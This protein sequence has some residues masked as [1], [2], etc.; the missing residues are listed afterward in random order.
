MPDIDSLQISISSNSTNAA[1]GI[2]RLSGSLETLK[3]KMAG[4][5]LRSLQF[6]AL[7]ASLK[8]L[9]SVAKPTGLNSTINALKKLPGVADELKKADLKTFTAQINQLSVAMAPLANQMSKISAGFASLP[10]N[11]GKASMAVNGYSSSA[12]AAT[13]A[14]KS[15]SGR[16]NGMLG[17]LS[18]ATIIRNVAQGIGSAVKTSMNYVENLNL[19]TV[20]MGEYA[21]EAQNYAEKVASIMGIDPSA[22]M[23]SQGVFMTLATGFGVSADR[24]N[25][26]SQNLTQLGYDLSSFFNIT[27]EDAME[28]LQSGISGELEPLRRLGYDLSQAKLEAT[29]LSLGIDKSVSSMTQAEKAQLRYYAIMTQVT[30]AQGDMARTLD[31]PA[32]QLRIFRAAIEQTSRAIGN[33]FIPALNKIFPYITAVVRAVQWVA[34]S[35]AGLFGFEITTVDYSGGISGIADG[36]EAVEDA[37]GGATGAAKEFKRQVMGFDELNILSSPSPSGG[38][39]G[40]DDQNFGDGFDFELPTYDFL[41]GVVESKAVGIF[42]DIKSLIEDIVDLVPKDTFSDLA[43]AFESLKTSLGDLAASN[44]AKILSELLKSIAA[45]G[46]EGAIT[47]LTNL[48]TT[49]SSFFTLIDSVIN[50]DFSNP[51]ESFWSL[52]DAG[53]ELGDSLA[54]I[55]GGPF[56]L[57]ASL[58]G[59][60]AINSIFGGE[61]NVPEWISSIISGELFDY[62]GSSEMYKEWGENIETYIVN[63]VE[64][65][66]EEI[67][68][69]FKDPGGWAKENITKP[70]SKKFEEAKEKVVGIWASVKTWFKTNVTEPIAGFFEEAKQNVVITW[71]S[72]TEWFNTN[73]KGPIVSTFEDVKQK[74][75]TRFETAK[76][77]VQNAWRT[78]SEWFNANVKNPVVSTFETLKQRIVTPIETAATAVKNAW[79]S[80]STWF[81]VNVVQPIKNLFKGIDIGLSI[82]WNYDAPDWQKTIGKALFGYNAWPQIGF[83]A[84]GGYGIPDGQLFVANE[85]GP[86]L[87][88]QMNGRN[89]VANQGQII[90][91]I[92]QATYEGFMAAMASAG[93]GNGTQHI[94]VQV[95]DGTIADVV[96]RAINKQ[97][98]ELG[99][100]ALEG[101]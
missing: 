21:D 16:F 27:V 9:M 55:M 53:N 51:L 98:Q 101:I 66:I 65:A 23:R 33:I 64:E 95:G 62:I 39:G 14:S 29:A 26:M 83:F 88:G 77:A 73:I 11:I 41:N 4:L 70:I 90:E 81:D 87:V 49:F 7:A 57:L 79:R 44:G 71:Q 32:N 69:I 96:V 61:E 18:A 2:D 67:K 80:I 54:K 3:T 59:E 92:R 76:T 78:I 75:V 34:E 60:K 100:L 20:A 47:S 94:T 12:V 30:T 63:P 58:L 31:Q 8:P 22:W 86:E 50:F 74:V 82:R 99:Y 1:K 45:L 97:T 17:G 13:T 89:T 28:K 52:V 24:A 25:L 6:K 35:I 19:F 15:F 5:N 37:F 10:K 85:A 46:L 43:E 38:G 91:G 36:V 84:A 40:L 72:I 56:V 42:E 48:V 93:N 68:E